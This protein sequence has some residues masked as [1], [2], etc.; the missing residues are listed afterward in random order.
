MAGIIYIHIYDIMINI[1]G[2]IKRN[3][4]LAQYRDIGFSCRVVLGIVHGLTT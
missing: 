4:W 3:G 2:K 1:E